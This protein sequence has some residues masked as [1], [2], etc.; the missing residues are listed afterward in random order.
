M[1]YVANASESTEYLIIFQGFKRGILYVHTVLQMTEELRTKIKNNK[2]KLNDY[3]TAEKNLPDLQ[4][5]YMYMLFS[6]LT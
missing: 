5:A 1:Q 2:D 4:F 6:N 3:Q